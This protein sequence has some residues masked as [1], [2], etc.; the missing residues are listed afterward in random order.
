MKIIAFFVSTLFLVACG[1]SPQPVAIS[2]PP[3][4]YPAAQTNAP[5]ERKRLLEEPTG[6]HPAFQGAFVADSSTTQLPEP[7]DW[8]DAASTFWKYAVEDPN[9][10]VYVSVPSDKASGD[11]AVDVGWITAGAIN[12]TTGKLVACDPMHVKLGDSCRPVAQVFPTGRFYVQLWCV[13]ASSHVPSKLQVAPLAASIQFT[14][15]KVDHWEQSHTLSIAS[16]MGAIVD[17]SGVAELDKAADAA[18]QHWDVLGAFALPNKVFGGVKLPDANPPGNA[19]LFRAGISDGDYPT[20]V[21][22]SCEN[23]PIVFLVLFDTFNYKRTAAA[24]R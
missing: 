6:N 21:G 4:T 23:K 15:E 17:E 13:S 19:I 14:K 2:T 9:G 10:S 18:R 20:F 22:F 8:L 24:K 5:D 3:T 1:Q 7:I 16:G 11:F 12:V